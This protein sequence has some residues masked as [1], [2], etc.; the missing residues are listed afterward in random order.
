MRAKIR[1]IRLAAW[2]GA[3]LL[4]MACGLLT[5]EPPSRPPKVTGT[6]TRVDTLMTVGPNPKPYVRILVEEEPGVVSCGEAKRSYFSVS[7]EFTTVLMQKPNGGWRHGVIADLQVGLLVSAWYGGEL[8]F[9][10]C[11]SKG[12]GRHIAVH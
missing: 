8:Y 4:S 12:S 5:T 1:H 3:L 10:T 6:I 9:Q 2:S 7:D 11:P